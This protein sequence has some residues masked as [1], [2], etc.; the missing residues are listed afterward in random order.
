MQERRERENLPMVARP[1]HLRVPKRRKGT[2]R[3]VM[4]GA[5]SRITMTF[6]GSAGIN[7]LGDIAVGVW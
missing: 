3:V 6:S 4:P 7:L 2:E 1:P 5:T